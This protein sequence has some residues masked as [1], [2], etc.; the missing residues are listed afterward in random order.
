[1]PSTIKKTDLHSGKPRPC[2][3]FL[4]HCIRFV[5]DLPL[6]RDRL[7]FPVLERQ[8][9]G[10]GR[11]RLAVTQ[12][13]HR[14]AGALPRCLIPFSQCLGQRCGRI[15]RKAHGS[16]NGTSGVIRGEMKSPAIS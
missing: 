5:A 1:M 14:V 12:D 2:L 4:H 11:S 15:D 10:H 3:P 6:H 13:P 7:F 9:T 8:I 16:Q